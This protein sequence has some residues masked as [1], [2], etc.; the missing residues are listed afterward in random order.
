MNLDS[1][2]NGFQSDDER[3]KELK[4]F[5]ATKMGVKGL[6]DSGVKI[7]PKIFM[8]PLDELSE[9]LKTPC[10]ELQVPVIS[11]EGLGEK[12]RYDKIVKEI[13]DAS[14]NWGFFQVVHHGI[15]LE[16]LDEMLQRV[17]MF[18]EQD[19]EVKKEFYTRGTTNQVVYNSNY[20]LYNSRAANW[21]DTLIINNYYDHLDPNELPEICRDVMLDYT[22]HVLKL[23]DILLELLSVA[24]GLIPDHLSKMEFKKGW[25]L[26][27]HYYPACPA[28]DLTLGASKHSD[29]AF[30][31]ILLQDQIGGLQVLHENQWVNVLPNP[32]AFVVNIGDILQMM[33]NNKFKSVYH[34]V[35]ANTIGPR[36]SVAFFL[37]GVLSSETLYGPINEL[38]SKE[39]PP[40]YR[41]FSLAE[42][43]SHFFSQALDESGFEY[44]KLQNNGDGN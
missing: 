36:I 34:R 44:F 37:R 11:L 42:F 4:A 41:D 19:T 24:L 16:L 38:L 30:L 9:D 13:L 40:V 28:P 14:E 3:M 27:N 35:I 39:N 8:R 25:S 10:V 5:D 6:V 7:L 2:T 1:I 12:N 15:P 21:K 26:V 33:T 43:Y 18:H 23:S 17:R 32:G 20:D 31:T 29:S 22:N